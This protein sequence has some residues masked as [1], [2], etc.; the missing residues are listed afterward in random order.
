MMWLDEVK[1]NPLRDPQFD[2]QAYTLAL[3]DKA[4]EPTCE[5]RQELNVLKANERRNEDDAENNL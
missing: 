2:L 3:V 5:D 1:K 4:L